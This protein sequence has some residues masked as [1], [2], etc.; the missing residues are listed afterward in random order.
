MA[1]LVPEER[2]S[3]VKKATGSSAAY[4]LYLRGRAALRDRSETGMKDA[5]RRFEEA[6]AGD[7]GYAEAYVGLADAYFLLGN[8]HHMPMAEAVEKGREALAKALELEDGLA[9][10]HTTLANYMVHD[11]KFVEAQSEFIRAI[12][13]SPS[14][15]LARH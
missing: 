9:E 13:I 5:K 7:A 2:K 14:Y 15:V 8:Y 6:I 3:I 11:Y 1:R 4:F 10:A 12:E